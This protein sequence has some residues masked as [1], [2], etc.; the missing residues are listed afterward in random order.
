MGF[1]S[2]IILPIELLAKTL[3][4]LCYAIRHGAI[5]LF[6]HISLKCHGVKAALDIAG[7]LNLINGPHFNYGGP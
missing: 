2:V 1:N 3:H 5:I 4:Q 7:L 6:L